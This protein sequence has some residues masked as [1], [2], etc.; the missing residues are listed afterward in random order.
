[1][2]VENPAFSMEV[3]HAPSAFVEEL[4]LAVIE[5]SS[6]VHPVVFPVTVI[7]TLIFV[8]EQALPVPFAMSDLTHIL[9][10]YFVLDD[11]LLKLALDRLD[12]VVLLAD[13]A[14]GRVVAVCGWA[15]RRGVRGKQVETGGSLLD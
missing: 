11:S 15:V 1:M 2:V 6:S 13:L 14:N 10:A 9:S 12:G 5:G 7:V 8:V 3:V 4:I